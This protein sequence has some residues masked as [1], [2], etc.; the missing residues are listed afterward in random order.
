M[1]A[2]DKLLKELNKKY[3]LSSTIP[4]KFGRY[5][6]VIK[7]NGDGDAILLFMGKANEDGTIKG[8]RFSRILIK[9]SSGKIVK[10]HWDHKGKI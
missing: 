4:L 1:K 10:D 5:D 8:N 7:T 9:D 2:G 3:A 6:L